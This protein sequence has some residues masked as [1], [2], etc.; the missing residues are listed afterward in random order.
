VP[1]AT[2]PGFSLPQVTVSRYL[3]IRSGRPGAFVANAG[4]K[5]PVM[6]CSLL[7]TAYLL[8]RGKAVRCSSART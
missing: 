7:I 1:E 2:N 4:V 3:T 6:L 5:I 8:R